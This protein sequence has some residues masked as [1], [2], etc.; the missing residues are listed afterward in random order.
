MLIDSCGRKI[1]S[2]RISLTDRCNLRCL[3]CV[4]HRDLSLSRESEILSFEEIISLIKCLVKLG[5]DKIKL[6]GGEPLL[7]KD[8]AGLVRRIVEIPGVQDLSL[9]TNG[10]LFAGY[11]VELKKAGLKRVTISLDSLRSERF[12]FLT[13]HNRI[14]EVVRSIRCALDSGFIPVKINV[15]MLKGINDD[16]IGG[17]ISL[18]RN[19]NLV[20]RFVEFMPTCNALEWSKYFISGTEVLEKIKEMGEV[21]P[22]KVFGS[23]PA[24]YF[25]V[26]GY[27][28][29][30]GLISP[31]SGSF[32]FSCNRLRITASGNLVL[33]L[34]RPV[35]FNLH[36]LLEKGSEK[37]VMEFIEDAVLQKPADH[38]LA[39]PD[40]SKAP[41][42][43]CR[44]GG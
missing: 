5:V 38:G 17:F 33:C 6:T 34:H 8:V 9:T 2:V 22:D 1:E 27:R 16:E 20:V 24:R 30:F 37:M 25:R 28:G 14:V 32:C 18:T 10:I 40:F 23:G 35:S 12:S 31:L 11:A 43:M 41:V 4:P 26:S 36:S 3:Y 15:V 42:S 44:I 21:G 29:S 13:G 39:S 19:H 7:R